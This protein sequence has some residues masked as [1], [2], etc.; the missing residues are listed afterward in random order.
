MKDREL[1]HVL[2]RYFGYKNFALS[3][4]KSFTPPADS[5]EMEFYYSAY[6]YHL[7]SAIDEVNKKFPTFLGELKR[8]ISLP[9]YSGQNN[10]RYISE[11]R[12]AII[13]RGLQINQV[14]HVIGE[15]VCPIAPESITDRKGKET[16]A[17]FGYYL[18]DI[19]NICEQVVGK[20]IY[21]TLSDCGY[22]ND[23]ERSEQPL[24]NQELLN[25][26]FETM[27]TNKF[28]PDAYKIMVNKDDLEKIDFCEM[29]NN[30][31]EKLKKLL[32]CF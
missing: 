13:H 7:C 12:N 22:F 32:L 28:I 4:I 3:K 25:Q 23:I 11:L 21:S 17:A 19:I 18:I 6:F 31:N 15:L 5:L 26:I 14:G 24:A 8:N 1:I 20:T 27:Q 16:F 9:S 2:T 30:Q 10:Y 29:H